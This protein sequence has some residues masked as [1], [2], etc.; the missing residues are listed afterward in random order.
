MVLRVCTGR[1]DQA[2]TTLRL[3][4]DMSRQTYNT[5]IIARSL[6]N[7]GLALSGKGHFAEAFKSV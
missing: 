4:L 6:A 3:A 1:Y 2:V 5:T 7:L